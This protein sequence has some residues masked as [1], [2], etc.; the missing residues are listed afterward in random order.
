MS[1]VAD[2]IAIRPDCQAEA[3]AVPPPMGCELLQQLAAKHADDRRVLDGLDDKL[4]ALARRHDSHDL[5]HKCIE[6]QII[7]LNAN[8]GVVNQTL[9]DLLL[10][11]QTA[12]TLLPP[13]E[14]TT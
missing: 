2:V 4:D 3:P 8:V 7:I 13:K 5:S 12:Q 14:L 1:D 9:K 6:R 11:M 10:H